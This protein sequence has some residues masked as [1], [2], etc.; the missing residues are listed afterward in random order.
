MAPGVIGIVC[1][2][3]NTAVGEAVRCRIELEPDLRWLAHFYS[4]DELAEHAPRLEPDVVLLDLDMPGKDALEALQELID[5]CPRT[6][7]IVLS[8][9]VSEDY[10]DR[11]IDAGAWGYIAKSEGPEVIITAVR[12]VMAGQVALGPEVA[13]QY[14]RVRAVARTS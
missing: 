1:V 14:L 4:A 9:Y 3:D 6:K 11:A 12:Q 8:G 13:K 2:D 10:I 7:T 5:A